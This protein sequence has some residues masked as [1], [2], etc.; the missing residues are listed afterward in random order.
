[1]TI[2]GITFYTGEVLD[3][4]LYAEWHKRIRI[5]GRAN[6]IIGFSVGW[7]FV[8]FIIAALSDKGE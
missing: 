5:K 4:T 8:G 2:L 6:R 1:M 3:E 7:V